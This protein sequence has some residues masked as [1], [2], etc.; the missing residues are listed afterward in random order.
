VDDF[1]GVE[2]FLL[3]VGFINGVDDSVG[4]GA[5]DAAIN[6]LGLRPVLEDEDV[7]HDFTGEM[8]IR[9]LCGEVI[10]SSLVRTEK[11]IGFVPDRGQMRLRLLSWSVLVSFFAASPILMACSLA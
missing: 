7:V 11:M 10:L 4:A 9:F 1:L 3:D 8:I 5:N 2:L 6:C